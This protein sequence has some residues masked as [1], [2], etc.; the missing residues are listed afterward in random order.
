MTRQRTFFLTPLPILFLIVTS[1]LSGCFSSDPGTGPG[2]GGKADS[3]WLADSQIAMSRGDTVTVILYYYDERNREVLDT[4]VYSNSGGLFST[5]YEYNAQGL[6]AKKIN[7]GDNYKSTVEYRYTADGDPAEESHFDKDGSPS[8]RWVMEY[9]SRRRLSRILN[10]RG[11][12]MPLVEITLYRFGADTLVDTTI[13]TNPQGSE[14][15]RSIF[16]YTN[17]FLT[18][19]VWRVP[20]GY[21]STVLYALRP[22]GKIAEQTSA[23][24]PG[25]MINDYDENGNVVRVAF[26][27]TDRNTIST[28]YRYS[29]K[30]WP[31][32]K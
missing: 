32:P 11:E 24:S 9:D 3:V 6:L 18:K 22:D 15:N 31:I 21:E 7:R 23:E 27:S 20:S 10:Y 13:N 25:G 5:R 1:L 28:E 30:R 2:P 29:W 4:C 26:Y 16:T 8:N 19:V 14:L 12:G 17:G